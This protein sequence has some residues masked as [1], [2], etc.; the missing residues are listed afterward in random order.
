M[1]SAIFE[2]KTH[3]IFLIILGLI[4]RRSNAAQQSVCEEQE[5]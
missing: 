4:A 2:K 3:F 1:F 5:G